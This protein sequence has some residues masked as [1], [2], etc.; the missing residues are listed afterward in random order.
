MLDSSISLCRLSA[1][2]AQVG[3]AWIAYKLN[4]DFTS[5]SD[6]QK[7]MDGSITPAVLGPGPAIYIVDDHHTL[8]ALDYSG[9]LDTKVTLN[10]ICDKRSVSIDEFWKSLQNEDLAYLAAHPIDKPDVLPMP[11]THSQLPSTFSF[12]SSNKSMS[13]DP[14]RS[15]AGYSRKVNALSPPAQT[16]TKSD[17]SHCERCM[18]RGCSGSGAGVSY[19]EFRWSYFMN[20]ATFY[21]TK[22]WASASDLNSFKTL[23]AGLGSSVPVSKVDVSQWESAAVYVIPL[24][25]S[26]ASGSYSLPSTIFPGSSALPGDVSGYGKLSKDPD[27]SAPTC[28]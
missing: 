20:D 3:Y 16:C 26:A 6:A 1:T 19:F 10:I 11:I 18:F 28:I 15:L 9:Y 7:Q 27:C 2:Q 8:S 23:Y 24:C 21:N 25:R 13:D 4:K 5:S 17:D 14:W 12:T 22:Y